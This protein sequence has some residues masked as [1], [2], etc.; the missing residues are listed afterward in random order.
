MKKRIYLL[1]LIVIVALSA[2]LLGCF[3]QGSRQTE[4]GLLLI[5]SSIVFGVTTSISFINIIQAIINSRSDIFSLC[6]AVFSY[7]FLII[8]F[9]FFEPQHY[10]ASILS[11][12]TLCG[13]MGGV[14]S[15]FINI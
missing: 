6:V 4:I 15:R 10:A 2:L 8:G 12:A 9:L 13:Y 14:I 5:T 11:F 7:N 1:D 3:V